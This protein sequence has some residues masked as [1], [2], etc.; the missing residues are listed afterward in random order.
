MA[1]LQARASH[2]A[3]A[4]NGNQRDQDP[5][6]RDPA[7]R[8]PA[9]LYKR[10][11]PGPHRLERGQVLRHQRLR[12]HGA[13]VEAIAAGGYQAT[14]VR[15]LI[16]LAGVSRRSFY[17]HFANKQECFLATF[18]LLARRAV[19]NVAA[20][21][22]VA[23][24]ADPQQRLGPPLATL[25]R[26]AVEDPK[27]MNLLIAGP[28]ELGRPGLRR[29]CQASA[30]CERMLATAFAA[31]DGA[32]S[33]PAAVLQAIAGGV[34][35]AIAGALAQPPGERDQ[36][37][38]AGEL[39]RWVT[40]FATPS[41]RALQRRAPTRPQ[42]RRRRA[43]GAARR[44]PPAPEPTAHL[45]GARLL[46]SA[47]RLVAVHGYGELTAPR[48]ADLAAVPIDDFPAAFTSAEDCFGAA[49]A[50]VGDGALRAVHATAV[51]EGEWAPGVRASV[52]SLLTH[53]ADQPL[54][55]RTLAE[56]AFLGGE[57]CA[58]ANAARLR[59]LAA[60]LIAHAPAPTPADAATA[61]LIAGALLHVLRCQL[62]LG[63][64]RALPLL[65]DQMA[66][67]VLAPCI[68]A[69]PAAATLAGP[70]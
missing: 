35:A 33:L 27:A 29:L 69:E 63:R 15:Q 25:A 7:P 56:L 43:D 22:D 60:A 9:P 8:D 5:A 58:V 55:A 59:A 38:L 44:Q 2:G 20:S 21:C 49:V 30:A 46:D 42:P 24:A 34:Q 65:A 41:A 32:D 37:R 64:V 48:I 62:N 16:A 17:E 50:D 26:F 1:S 47:L 12:I 54:R 40:T 57:T 13:M 36:A 6:P 3:D 66:F 67:V 18:D 52:T 61:D 51:P 53:L 14:S 70:S 31:C 68:G 19:T 39:L 4:G 45:V 23:A 28:P 10:L 11:P